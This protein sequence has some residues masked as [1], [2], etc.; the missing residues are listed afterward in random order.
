MFFIELLIRKGKRIMRIEINVH[1]ETGIGGVG[2]VANGS[3]QEAS[4]TT[5]GRRVCITG[6]FGNQ[7]QATIILTHEQADWIADQIRKTG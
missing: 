6:D 1:D 7:I 5:S 2:I 3:L 4:V